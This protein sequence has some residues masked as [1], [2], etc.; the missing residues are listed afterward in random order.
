M[1]LSKSNSQVLKKY[2]SRNNLTLE[3]AAKKSQ[4]TPTRLKNIEN[5]KDGWEVIMQGELNRLL[6]VYNVQQSYF[7]QDCFTSI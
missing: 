6:E 5:P 2:R 7:I 4:I 1:Y 3:D